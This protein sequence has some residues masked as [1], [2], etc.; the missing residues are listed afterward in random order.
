[1]RELRETS[2]RNA[3]GSAQVEAAA[4]SVEGAVTEAARVSQEVRSN[5]AELGEISASVQ[6]VSTLAGKLGDASARLDSAVNAFRTGDKPA[7]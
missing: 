3:E 7:A 5:I 4:L 1:M 2:A 6:E